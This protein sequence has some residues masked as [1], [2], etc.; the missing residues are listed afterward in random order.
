MTA[1][2]SVMIKNGHSHL[3]SMITVLFSIFPI[4]LQAAALP[5]SKL[6]GSTIL[7]FSAKNFG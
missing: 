2:F 1:D 4:I 7:M 3:V 6:S 5:I